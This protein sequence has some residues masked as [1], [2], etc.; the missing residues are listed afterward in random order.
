[1]LPGLGKKLDEGDYI[2]SGQI[3][4]W[5]S[6]TC[7]KADKP[8][9]KFVCPHE[10]DPTSEYYIT[11][12]PIWLE[13]YS[14]QPPVLKSI[15]IHAIS[16]H[17]A[18]PKSVESGQ[19]STSYEQMQKKLIPILVSY[20]P[21]WIELYT[22]WSQSHDLL[23]KPT[24]TVFWKHMFDE[25]SILKIPPSRTKQQDYSL[26][27][28]SILNPASEVEEDSE[29]K[30][31]KLESKSLSSP[32]TD[33]PTK[34]VLEE[35][36]LRENMT[37]WQVKIPSETKP[38]GEVKKSG[39]IALQDAELSIKISPS[40]RITAARVGRPSRSFVP[41]TVEAKLHYQIGY[42]FKRYDGEQRNHLVC[43]A[44]LREISPMGYAEH[45]A[46][47]LIQSVEEAWRDHLFKH[48][49]LKDGETELKV[50]CSGV[51][52]EK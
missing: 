15:R 5:L 18:N 43:I 26:D 30:P 35:C 6:E 45:L 52:W 21:L 20:K 23:A 8:C 4:Y 42:H 25:V 51:H 50:L 2:P 46:M 37:L 29:Y 16:P 40:P 38:L 28:R 24:H 36:A 39:H 9:S 31:L 41:K 44:F 1:M 22:G 7:D 14:A 49:E 34:D 27:S 12:I 13:S 3:S 17:Q 33:I 47:S 19:H 10:Y 11:A 32:G 48:M